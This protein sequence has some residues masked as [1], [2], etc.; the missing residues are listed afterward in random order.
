VACVTPPSFALALVTQ[1]G[2]KRK[3]KS[4]SAIQVK[5]WQKKISIKEKLDVVS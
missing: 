5:N 3:P 2:E 4:P 1:M